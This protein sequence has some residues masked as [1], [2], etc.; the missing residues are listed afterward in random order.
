MH[1]RSQSEQQGAPQ[2]GAPWRS[3][4]T[5]GASAPRRT[6]MGARSWVSLLLGALLVPGAWSFLSESEEELLVEMHN[7]YRGRV[8]PSASAMMPLKWDPNLKLVAEGYAAKC[9]WNHNPALDD[10]GENLFVS[11]G[12]LDLRDALEK[13]FLEHL[14]FDYQNNSC[15]EDKMCG[16]YTQMVWGDTHRVGCAFHLC[17]TME[18]LDWERVSFLVCNYFPAGNFEDQ[19]P[20]VE[21]DWCS[22]CPENLQK[23]ENNLCVPDVEEEEVTVGSSDPPPAASPSSTFTA[24]P[25]ATTP[26]AP[27]TPSMTPTARS[28][29]DS[30]PPGTAEQEV[31]FSPT[32][33]APR[34]EEE[35]G[36]SDEKE[37]EERVIRKQ[38]IWQKTFP[39]SNISAGSGSVSAAP[40]LLAG[41]AGLLTLWL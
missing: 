26:R 31:F 33:R 29:A 3:S 5:S 32:S 27:N 30:P 38:E 17:N 36:K 6:P 25:A 14:N 28:A 8:S 24:A 41:L 2:V 22:S 10:T 39:Q 20:Y 1:L 21:G 23:C 7:F 34:E 13:W 37:R 18:L 11:S 35:A 16:H 15:D 9:I 19:R 40:V 4:R 12:P